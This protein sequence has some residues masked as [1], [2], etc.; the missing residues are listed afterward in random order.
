VIDTIRWIL[1]AL[2]VPVIVL[3]VIATARRAREL[4]DRIEEHHKEEEEQKQSGEPINPYDAM[5]RIMDTRP[6]PK[7]DKRKDDR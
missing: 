7:R 5:S 3:L 1:I 2:A 6:K 4:S